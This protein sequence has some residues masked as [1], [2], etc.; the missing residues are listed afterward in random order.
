MDQIPICTLLVSKSVEP[1]LQVHEW[2]P[3]KKDNITLTL[4]MIHL[5]CMCTSIGNEGE[6]II[7][8]EHTSHSSNIETLK[9][10]H[11]FASDH[12][13][14]IKPYP[15]GNKTL[16]T[17]CHVD[18]SSFQISL[19]YQALRISC[20]V[21]MDWLWLLDRSHNLYTMG[22]GPS[23]SSVMWPPIYLIV[24]GLQT[25]HQ[26]LLVWMSASSRDK[27]ISLNAKRDNI[28]SF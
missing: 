15:I 14:S 6:G 8:Y 7:M 18:L 3:K 20:E 11:S 22:Q 28:A 24:L 5:Y 9:Q 13:L 26:G 19:V 10:Y 27:F 23:S 21:N 16:F 12:L 25:M 2:Y 4:V 1:S 17:W